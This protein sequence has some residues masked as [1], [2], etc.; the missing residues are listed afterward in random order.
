MTY[1]TPTDDISLLLFGNN[2]DKRRAPHPHNRVNYSNKDREENYRDENPA[3]NSSLILWNYDFRLQQYFD[4]K[5]LQI[6][7][8]NYFK[9]V[10]N[11]FSAIK[12]ISY[13]AI[14]T[15]TRIVMIMTVFMLF[16]LFITTIKTF[17]EFEVFKTLKASKNV[18]KKLFWNFRLRFFKSLASIVTVI[19][20]ECWIRT[21]VF[22]I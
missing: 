6:V 2:L 21:F 1:R 17:R 13:E 19:L 12:P 9:T 11:W 8:K 3:K 10:L 18:V 4:W 5:Q 15:E 16:L 22:F 7:S 20:T 14:E